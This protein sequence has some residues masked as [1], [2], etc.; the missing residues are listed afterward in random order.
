MRRTAVL[1]LA[2]TFAGCSTPTAPIVI[3]GSS[4]LHPITAQAVKQYEKQHGGQAFALRESSTG[5]GLAKFCAGEL[6]IADAS[7]HITADEQA[8]CAKGGVTFIEVPIAYDAISV[9]VS[10]SNSWATDMTVP[11]LKKL[12]EPAAEKKVTKWNQIRADWPDREIHLYGPD[13]QSGTFDYF[14]EAIVGRAKASRTDYSADADDT[15]LAA[16][17]EAD[18][19]GLAYFGYT[20]F[21]DRTDRLRGVAINDL[22]DEIGPGAIEPSA[23]NVR[24][25]VYAPLSRTLFLYVKNTALDRDEVRRFVEFYVRLSP[26]L[27]ERAGGVRLN[28]GESELALARL[29]HRTLGTMFLPGSDPRWTLQEMLEAR[30]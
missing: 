22:D 10:R 14:T 20:Y 18:E 27:A 8:A 30:K 16:A 15:K 3:E 2:V 25:G 12:W 29:T 11:E 13:R 5:A 4:T 26:E 1:A 7:R 6:D 21:H 19:L 17:V 9:V 24:R 28:A 23:I